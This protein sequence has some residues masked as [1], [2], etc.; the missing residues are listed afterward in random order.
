MP[1]LAIGTWTNRFRQNGFTLL[2]VMVTVVLIGIIASFAVLSMRGS[3]VEEHTV[4]EAQRLTALIKLNQQEAILQ[5]EQRGV[6]FTETGYTF[7]TQSQ[8]GQWSPSA[9]SSLQNA[10]QLPSGF[11]LKLWTEGQPVNL[12][13]TPDNL[14]QVLLLSSGEITEFSVA[15]RFSEEDNHEYR[16]SGDPTGH[17]NLESVP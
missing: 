12:N 6:R 10:H 16:L 13:A 7:L 15:F 8:D 9:D 1:T 5:G 4:R 2:E 3:D 11:N 14:P 17:L